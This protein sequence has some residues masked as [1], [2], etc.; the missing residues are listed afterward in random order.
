MIKGTVIQS[1]GSWYQVNTGEETIACRLPGKF[2]LEEKDVTNPIAVGDDVIISMNEDETGRIEE[3]LPRENYVPRSA[4]HGKRGDQI[5]VANIDRAFVVQSIRKPKLKEGFTD[6]FLVTCEAY[7]IE[8]CIIINKADLATQN[9]LA[10]LEE[11]KERYEVLGYKILITSAEKRHDLKELE[12]LLKDQTSVFIGPSG[13]GKTS[14]I[15]AIDPEY[16]LK[17]GEISSYSNKGKH[18]TTFA[19]LIPLSAGGY[20]VDTPGIREFG[21]VNIEPWELSLFFPEMLEPRTRCKFN[22]CTHVHEPGC[23]VIDAFEQGQID[24]G[25]YNS[26]LNML[27]SLQD[28]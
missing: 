5:L 1:T 3:I 23:G 17:V 15:N 6:R 28:E 20:I 25:R 4:T 22:N 10:F 16:N 9:D 13:V 27:E 8:P 12:D 2:R 18:T 24:P 14:L 11:L 21:L 7:E 26:Y 19:R